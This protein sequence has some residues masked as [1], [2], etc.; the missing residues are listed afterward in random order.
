MSATTWAL[1]GIDLSVVLAGGSPGLQPG[2]RS[3]ALRITAAQPAFYREQAP[4]AAQGEA[5]I[6]EKRRALVPTCV[7]TS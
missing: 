2:P 6:P 7:V 4:R 5:I 3:P 1:I